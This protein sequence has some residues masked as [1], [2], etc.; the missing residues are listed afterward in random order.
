MSNILFISEK[1]KKDLKNI[2]KVIYNIRE[3]RKR[4]GSYGKFN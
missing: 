4:G 3:Q 2:M 1:I